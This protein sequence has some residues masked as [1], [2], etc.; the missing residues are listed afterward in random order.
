[1]LSA[2]TAGS[3]GV[4]SCLFIKTYFYCCVF[5][6]FVYIKF[7]AWRGNGSFSQ[8]GWEQWPRRIEGEW[9]GT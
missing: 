9:A 1:M 2:A 5:Y 6:M 8:D 7:I 3:D 4:S